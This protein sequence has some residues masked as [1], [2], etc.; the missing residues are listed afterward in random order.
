MLKTASGSYKVHTHTHTHT[1]TPTHIFLC[2]VAIQSCCILQSSNPI[3]A[4][5]LF[6][7]CFCFYTLHSTHSPIHPPTHLLL[8]CT[9]FGWTTMRKHNQSWLAGWLFQGGSCTHVLCF[10]KKLKKKVRYCSSTSSLSVKKAFS[11]GREGELSWSR[12]NLAPPFLEIQI[13]IQGA[14]QIH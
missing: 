11:S 4:P 12:C 8:P 5:F 9:F 1:H 14:L 2:L 10:S 6:D 13:R 7:F 3:G